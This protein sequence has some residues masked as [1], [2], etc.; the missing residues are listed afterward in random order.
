MSGLALA[1]DPESFRGC[2]TI[3]LLTWGPEESF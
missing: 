1:T 3:E 2:S